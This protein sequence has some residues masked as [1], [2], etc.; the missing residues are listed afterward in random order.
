MGILGHVFR[1]LL[2]R[3]PVQ[4]P[5]LV[6]ITGIAVIGFGWGAVDAYGEMQDQRWEKFE[7]LQQ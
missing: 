2:A 4:F 5:M 7:K 6:S 3:H 1:E